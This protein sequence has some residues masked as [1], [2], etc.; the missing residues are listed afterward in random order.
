MELLGGE[1]VVDEVELYGRL[2][3]ALREVALVERK[4]ELAVFE[5]VIRAGLV[6]SP[7]GRLF[8]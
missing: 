5:H 3:D 2:L 7:S 4:A 6:I 1:A 8:H